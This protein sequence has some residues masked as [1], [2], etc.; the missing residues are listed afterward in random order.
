MRN[1]DLNGQFEAVKKSAIDAL[2]EIFPVEGKKR[3]LKAESIWVED[4]ASATDFAAQASIKK[5]DGTWGVPV[6]ASMVLID[7]A[8]GK[9]IDKAPKVKIFNLPK[10]TDRYSYIVRGNEYQ[11][12]NQL[13]LKPGVYTLRKQNGELKTQINLSKGKNFDLAFNEANGLFTIQKVG[14]G[15]ANIPLYPILVHLGISA[16]AISSAWGS[17]L[18]AANRQ[19][20]PKIL[21]KAETAFGVKK[22]SLKDYLKETTIS[23]ETT[24]MV[25]GQAFDK[26]DGPMLLASSKNLLDT[27]TGKKE[28]ID[29]DSLAFKELWSVEDFIHERI[30][31]NKKALSYKVNRNIDNPKRDK[32]SQILSAGAFSSTVESFFTQDDKSNTPEQI[33][34]LEMLAGQYRVT[35]MGG[36]GIKSDHAITNAMRE[37]HPSHYGMI[38]PIHSPE[39]NVGVNMN[40]PLGAVKDGKNL[41]MAVHDKNKKVSFLT[42]TEAYDKIIAFPNQTG[43]KVKAMHRGKIVE[44]SRN[45]V[46]FFTPHPS[47]LFAP[48][49]N[50][51]P[52]LPTDQGNR[53]MMASKQLEQAISLKSREA[54][55][56]QV[57]FSPDK[58]MEEVLGAQMALRAT[59]D[60]KV[61]HVT[62]D[63]LKIK[64]AN[65]ETKTVNLYNNFVLNRKSFI[66]HTSNVK[67]GDSVKKGQL[68][69][70]SN[71]TKGGV[72]ALGTNLRA[73]Y[74]P[75]G[76]RTFDDGIVITESAAEKLTSEHIYKKDYELD[77]NAVLS[78]AAYKS[79]YPNILSGQNISKLDAQGVIAKGSIVK[80]GDIL[81]AALRRRSESSKLALVGKGLSNRPKDDS[82]SWN[83]EDDGIVMDVI[84][85]A[86]HITVTIKTEE[87]AKIGDKLSGRH[88][89]K[90]VITHIL[91]D[92][93]A[94]HSADGKAVDILLN[95]VGVISRIN[96]GQI[97]ESAVGKAAAKAGLAHKVYNFTGEDY[98]KHTKDFLKK[99]AV[100]DK[101]ELF[102]PENGKSMGMVHVGLPHILKLAKQSTSNFSVRQGGP[103]NPYDI[104]MQPTKG[105]E[106]GS[107]ALDQLTLYS[108]LSHGARANLREMSSIKSNANDEYWKALKSGQQLPPAKSPFVYDKFISYLKAAGVDV[109]KE[110]TKLMLAPLTDAQ[111]REIS[112]GAIT[113]AHL[114]RP[115]DLQPVKGG[116]FDPVIL[117]GYKGTKWGHME[118]Q[119][120]LVNPV[121]ENAARKLTGLGKKFDEIVAGK[122]HITSKGDLN[123][124]GKGLTGGAAIE[125]ILKGIDVDKE[126]ETYRSRSNE[127]RAPR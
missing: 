50:L 57:G 95:P 104:N 7:K 6:Y 123:S 73:A 16:S 26:V 117:G 22:G 2:K 78:L 68:L 119:E 21:Q 44:V 17:K 120:P 102:N 97:Y 109:K 88:G 9:V 118:L 14:G 99:N 19:T 115:K 93:K 58:S 42:P 35:V 10:I 82:V 61:T 66:H 103:G 89:N 64:G 96:L 70:D 84:K 38:D 91:P 33:N 108:M 116:V 28:P 62:P 67:A 79:N 11:V 112:N 53:A 51:I 20:D 69:A 75:Y 37:I 34:P 113:K 1:F 31:G 54:P 60:G 36:G 39:G 86:K 125:Q 15:Q 121:F 71:Y 105:G 55:H 127:P 24:K 59:E 101:E 18:E 124:D 5:K 48:S 114:Y 83:Y 43:G 98:L 111:V 80:T 49:T 47:A 4:N 23:P 81:I 27:H 63:Y 126:I 94:P 32:I 45:E 40:I 92:S 25:L 74:M 56:V 76:G 87:R 106:E 3:E 72:L 107:K 12:T 85:T 65:G 100:N 8:T 52:F 30:Q 110:G 77:E 29:R 90:G 13:R 46:D 122:M 41:K